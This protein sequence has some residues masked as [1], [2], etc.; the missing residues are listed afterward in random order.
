M[1]KD[2]LAYKKLEVLLSNERTLLS[3]IRTAAS[4]LVLAIGL[5][6]FFED[7]YAHY[8]GHTCVIIGLGIIGLGMYRYSQLKKR[9]VQENI[10]ELA[11]SN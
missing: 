2:E 3:Y 5:Y 4:V 10:E 6:K 1:K 9:V 8:I 7:K 11:Q